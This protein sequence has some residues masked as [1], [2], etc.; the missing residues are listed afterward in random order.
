MENLIRL[1]IKHQLDRESIMS[2]PRYGFITPTTL[3]NIVLFNMGDLHLVLP[4]LN[5]STLNAGILIMMQQVRLM[6]F[7]LT[8]PCPSS[9]C[10]PEFFIA[11]QVGGKVFVKLRA[12]SE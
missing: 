2:S 11:G 5:L 6:M 8:T 3:F 12:N 4:A 9:R 7:S 1:I 10:P